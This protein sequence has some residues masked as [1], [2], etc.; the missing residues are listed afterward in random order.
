[1]AMKIFSMVIV[2]LMGGPQKP[3]LAQQIFSEITQV[4]MRM[5]MNI[6]YLK[7]ICLQKSDLQGV[8][9]ILLF[10]LQSCCVQD[11]VY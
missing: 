9:I 10:F 1:M 2:V 5:E 4:M 3:K 11:T 7:S 8:N 6:V